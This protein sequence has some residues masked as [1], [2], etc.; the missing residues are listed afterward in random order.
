MSQ[1]TCAPTSPGSCPR[2][3][4]LMSSSPAGSPPCP[5]VP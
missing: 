1:L 2:R 3:C 4:V 5:S